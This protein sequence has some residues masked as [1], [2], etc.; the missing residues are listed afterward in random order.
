MQTAG[1]PSMQAEVY[2]IVDDKLKFQDKMAL[3]TRMSYS[4]ITTSHHT[5]S[6]GNTYGGGS[7]LTFNIGVPDGIFIDSQVELELKVAVVLTAAAITATEDTAITSIENQFGFHSF[8][9]NRLI[10]SSDVSFNNQSS[11]VTQ[12]ARVIDSII[13]SLDSD[14]L[15]RLSDLYVPDN[16]LIYDASSTQSVL[17]PYR[18]SIS[19][20][21]GIGSTQVVISNIDLATHTAKYTFTIKEKLLCTPFQ[22]HEKN[23]HPFY[24]IKQFNMTLNLISDIGS[25]FGRTALV[26]NITVP[27][28]TDAKLLLHQYVP[29]IKMQ[30]PSTIYY[31]CIIPDYSESISSTTV[32]TN[33]ASSDLIIN[34]K[35]Y[36]VVP[37]LF[38]LY[39]TSA[40]TSLLPFQSYPISSL[41]VDSALKTS[42][43]STYTL[44]DFYQLSKNNGYNQS[45][46]V[47]SGGYYQDA[48]AIKN[49]LTTGHMLYFT[50]S[51]MSSDE[52][53]Q[54]NSMINYNFGLT[55]NC[56]NLNTTAA[57][58]GVKAILVSFSDN[59]LKYDASNGLFTMTNAGVTPSEI[60]NAKTM[61]V[62]TAFQEQILG[63]SFWSWIK[64]AGK[65]VYNFIKDNKDTI[66]DIRKQIPYTAPGTKA[67]EVLEKLG[68]GKR[69]RPKKAKGNGVL[70]LGG[71]ANVLGG[72]NVSQRELLNLLDE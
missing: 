46:S 71:N 12:I 29:S 52:G 14:Q 70:E 3:G 43:F 34:N 63:G 10:Q 69:K 40:R 26:T 2:N 33:T 65:D 5:P 4:S 32:N 16:N 60:A 47:F 55:V 53:V 17:K 30:I 42:L 18:E 25:I 51:D 67:G 39:C 50:C 66:R 6:E 37:K 57:V 21:R 15:K 59:I 41:K 9:V 19:A 27:V 8:P 28:L 23:P 72:K 31:N 22:W 36:S 45:Y 38:V 49:R 7:S 48:V 11:M 35:N 62:N 20:T 61:F 58:V 44:R 54:S 56:F 1:E 24:G 68:L 64:Q 13:Y